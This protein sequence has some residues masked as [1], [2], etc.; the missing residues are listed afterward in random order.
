MRFA[1]LLIGIVVLMLIWYGIEMQRAYQKFSAFEPSVA[2]TKYGN[3]SY[4]DQ[5]DGVPLL[6][7]H[8]ICGGYDQGVVTAKNAL[9]H[10][11]DAYRL[12]S[13]SRFGYPGSDLT[14]DG[15][16]QA[17]ADAF[18]ARTPTTI[19]YGGT[20]LHPCAC[21]TVCV[22]SLDRYSPRAHGTT[23]SRKGRVDCDCRPPRFRPC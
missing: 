16:P 13:P 11:I 6:I 20:Q 22:Y 21:A 18:R 12:I 10:H 19:C 3:I 14:D 15:S 1:L 8:G 7:S 23:R 9:G 17:Q 5:G 4:M 2:K